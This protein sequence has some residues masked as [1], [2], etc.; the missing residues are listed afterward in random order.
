LLVV[1]KLE[2]YI[3]DARQCQQLAAMTTTTTTARVLTTTTTKVATTAATT[4]CELTMKFAKQKHFTRFC[5]GACQND[6]HST[7]NTHS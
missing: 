3:I 1:S 7:D 2:N 4:N 6:A 5:F